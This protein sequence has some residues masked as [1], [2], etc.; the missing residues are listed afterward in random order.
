MTV[1]KPLRPKSSAEVEALFSIR[2]DE[3]L[4]DRM[5]NPEIASILLFGEKFVEN[6]NLTCVFNLDADYVLTVTVWANEV[7]EQ[8]GKDEEDERAWH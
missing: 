5:N 6:C 1:R 7:K 3:D 4:N 2:D 8:V